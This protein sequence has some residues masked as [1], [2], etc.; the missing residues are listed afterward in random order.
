MFFGFLHSQALSLSNLQDISPIWLRFSR[1]HHD[2]PMV[3]FT[4]HG[5]RTTCFIIIQVLANVHLPLPQNTET[6]ITS[7]VRHTQV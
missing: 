7:A 4:K 2:N 1:E 6:R 3:V 5:L